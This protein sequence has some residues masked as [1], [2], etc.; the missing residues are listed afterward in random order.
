MTDPLI[1]Y[2]RRPSARRL[3]RVIRS[4]YTTVWRVARRISGSEED[5]ADICQDVFLKLLLSPPDPRSIRSP[6]GYLAWR[7]LGRARFLQRSRQ[8]Q[9]QRETQFAA[10]AARRHLTDEPPRADDDDRDLVRARVA[11]L[12]EELRDAVELRYFANLPAKESADTLGIS[13]RALYLRLEKAR[14]R[15]RRMLAPSALSVTFAALST[16]TLHPAPPSALLPEL[17]KVARDGTALHA[18]GG[19]ATPVLLGGLIVSKKTLAAVSIAVLLLGLWA[20]VAHQPTER[21]EP[22]PAPEFPGL[23]T[24]APRDKPTAS[25]SDVKPKALETTTVAAP[26][27]EPNRATLRGRVSNDD[28]EPLAGVELTLT[29]NPRGVD[30]QRLEAQGF[31]DIPTETIK[32]ATTSAADGTFHLTDLIPNAGYVWAAAPEY[33]SEGGHRVALTAGNDS[34]IDVRLYPLQRL[35]GRLTNASDANLGDGT[36]AF[37]TGLKDAPLRLGRGTDVDYGGLPTDASGHFDTGAKLKLKPERAIDVIAWAPGHAM[38]SRRVLATEFQSHHA[39]IEFELAPELLVSL[40]VRDPDGQPVG[41]AEIGLGD[42]GSIHGWFPYPLTSTDAQG[43]ATIDHLARKPDS[44]RIAKNG[45]RPAAVRI[46]PDEPTDVSVTLEP[47]RTNAIEAT[48]TFRGEMTLRRGDVRV[49][50]EKRDSAGAWT[51]AR[52]V[53]VK[54]DPA[55]N[56][57]RMWPRQTGHYRLRYRHHRDVFVTEPFEYTDEQPVRVELVVQ[58]D[59]R[60]P[61]VAGTAVS[62]ETGEPLPH[63]LIEA[64]WHLEGNT[65]SRWGGGVYVYVGDRSFHFPPPAGRSA[66][67]KADENGQFVL[68]PKLEDSPENSSV[69]D[70]VIALQIRIRPEGIAV[71]DGSADVGWSTET[72]LTLNSETAISDVR[73]VVDRPASIEGTVLTATGDPARGE[74]V[75]A[76]DRRGFLDWA[77][78]DDRGGFHFR[79][80]R[81]GAYAIECLGSAH[82]SGIG[83]HG[84]RADLVGLPTPEEFFTPRVSLEPGENKRLSLDLSND[85][86]G[87]IEGSVAESL[88]LNDPELSFGMIVGGRPRE[89]VMTFGGEAKIRDGQFRIAALF[90]GQ[91]RVVLR[92]QHAAT[93]RRQS[94]YAVET[95]HVARGQTVPVRLRASVALLRIPLPIAADEAT[96]TRLSTLERFS[97]FEEDGTERWERVGGYTVSSDATGLIVR[98]VVPGRVRC[99]VIAP[100]YRETPVPPL[101]LPPGGDE[102]TDRVTLLGGSRLIVRLDPADGPSP[103]GGSGA[104]AGAGAGAQSAPSQKTFRVWGENREVPHSVRPGEQ[105]GEWI[106]SAFSPGDYTVRYGPRGKSSARAKVRIEAGVDATVT[107]SPA[108]ARP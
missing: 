104:Q 95:V 37:R 29:Q 50:L 49:D 28:D 86:L 10:D 5:A 82:R 78:A 56:L 51:P 23:T 98:G 93:R 102:T 30:R 45:F 80:L 91:Y 20:T 57:H 14:A 19:S 76:T 3:A 44:L 69:A 108:A 16:E 13:E 48:V 81:S 22:Q 65:P 38:A 54:I 59:L 6:E 53:R 21:S 12:P 27:V 60:P 18:L 103:D 41:D 39:R 11:A 15:L 42:I 31:A 99:R 84:A 46:G 26:T 107:L 73:L 9:R 70:S 89:N 105:A 43:F 66:F 90:P 85:G 62:G 17:L 32:T 47:L 52:E 75:V 67:V 35:S 55:A 2:A 106:L 1:R 4:H 40:R 58:L 36:V 96:Y 100:G 64:H 87:V 101:D 24:A 7:A 63:A 74:F 8:R 92:G 34:W 94:V 77:R 61:F 79:G 68:L 25:P 72:V 88:T 33:F 83:S 71:P 97:C